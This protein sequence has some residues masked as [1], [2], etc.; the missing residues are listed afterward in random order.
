MEKLLYIRHKESNKNGYLLRRLVN[1]WK[2][3]WAHMTTQGL[4]VT[5]ICWWHYY[6]YSTQVFLK[7]YKIFNNIN[8]KNSQPFF[9]VQLLY[10]PSFSSFLFFYK[11]FLYWQSPFKTVNCQYSCECICQQCMRPSGVQIHQLRPLAAALLLTCWS[12]VCTYL[13]CDAT[14]CTCMINAQRSW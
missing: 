7:K 10:Q 4:S 5:R 6:N 9:F 12:Q 11:I 2:H 14:T 1:M 13:P 3:F 8:K